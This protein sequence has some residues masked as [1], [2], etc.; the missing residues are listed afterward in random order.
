VKTGNISPAASASPR[1]FTIE[2]LLGDAVGM[3]LVSRS[4]AAVN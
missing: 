4:S 1:E 3:T 2:M